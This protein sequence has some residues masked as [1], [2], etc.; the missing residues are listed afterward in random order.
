MDLNNQTDSQ[1]EKDTKQNALIIFMLEAAVYIGLKKR[2]AYSDPYAEVISFETMERLSHDLNCSYAWTEGFWTNA[3][4]R[5]AEKGM[6]VLSGYDSKNLCEITLTP[7]SCATIS[8]KYDEVLIFAK[9]F[10]NVEIPN[11]DDYIKYYE[12]TIKKIF[13]GTITFSRKE[14]YKSNG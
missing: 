8:E 6:V 4:Y 7:F 12:P 13:S 11:Y 5:L 1:L 3:V 9:K 2:K 14:S 10:L